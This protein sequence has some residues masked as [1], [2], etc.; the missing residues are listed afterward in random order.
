MNKVLSTLNRAAKLAVASC[1][2]ELS[3][4]FLMLCAAVVVGIVH[5]VFASILFLLIIGTTLSV[6]FYIE[7]KDRE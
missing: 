7:W 1:N 5:W 4:I 3:T 6:A 2:Y